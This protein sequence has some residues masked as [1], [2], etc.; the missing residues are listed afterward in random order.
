MYGTP[1]SSKKSNSVTTFGWSSAA[2]SRA[3]RTKRWASVGSVALELQA[4]E[5]DLAI[6]RRLYGEIHDGHPAAC[7]HSHDLVASD[8]LFHGTAASLSPFKNA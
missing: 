2:A 1:S 3:S 8:V 6:K 4:L 7:Q 5:R